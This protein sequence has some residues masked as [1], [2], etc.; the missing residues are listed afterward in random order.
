[1]HFLTALGLIFVIGISFLAN[2]RVYEKKSVYYHC[3]YST[4]Q[5]MCQIH[6]NATFDRCSVECAI[7][8]TWHEDK[9]KNGC[10]TRFEGLVLDSFELINN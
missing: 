9:Q 10:P 6:P 2:R 7:G 8:N 1:M 3:H 5:C 4:L